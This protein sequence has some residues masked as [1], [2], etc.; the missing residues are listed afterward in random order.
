MLSSFLLSFLNSEVNGFLLALKTIWTLRFVFCL[1][2]DN[3]AV[4]Q[5][6]FLCWRGPAPRLFQNGA[7][8]GAGAGRTRSKTTQKQTQKPVQITPG[9]LVPE[10]TVRRQLGRKTV[11]A[12]NGSTKRKEMRTTRKTTRPETLLPSQL[13][14]KHLCIQTHTTQ[15]LFIYCEALDAYKRLFSAVF[16]LL[17]FY[18][19]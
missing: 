12:E 4:V 6:T 14:P 16:L 9:A 13:R 3:I 18:F 11:R 19:C 8:R 2:S 5:R 7:G 10:R 17:C 15:V 1:F